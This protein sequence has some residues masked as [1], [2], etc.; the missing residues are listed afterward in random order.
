MNNIETM[1]SF[2]DTVSLPLP[3]LL[4]RDRTGIALYEG[5]VMTQPSD[6]E[7]SYFLRPLPFAE[8]TANLRLPPVYNTHGTIFCL[9]HERRKLA[10]YETATG[11][12]VMDLDVLDATKVEF[13]P[14][15]RYMVTF[16]LPTKVNDVPIANLRVWN[17]STGALLASYVQKTYKPHLFQW[18]TNE[19]HAFRA[20]NNEIYIYE[21]GKYSPEDTLIKLQHKGFTQ[22]KAQA[23]AHDLIHVAVFNPE[24]GGKPGIVSVY[25]V[26][27]GASVTVEGPVASR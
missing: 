9:L 27:L 22:F 13:S 1:A 12:L 2:T 15:G 19:S 20:S 6:A 26:K 21:D 7:P 11:S 3:Q 8:S 18:T 10:L 25:A 23:S 24:A 14:Q 16:S 17:T 4:I 5:P